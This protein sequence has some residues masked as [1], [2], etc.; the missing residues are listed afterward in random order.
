[1]PTQ[2]EHVTPEGQSADTEHMDGVEHEQKHGQRQSC[3]VGVFTRSAWQ[4]RGDPGLRNG[5]N[6]CSR[7]QASPACSG[8][9]G[10]VSISSSPA[11]IGEAPL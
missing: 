11:S 9:E 10:S 2:P 3:G 1:M 6:A 5:W 7:A 4:R 8:A